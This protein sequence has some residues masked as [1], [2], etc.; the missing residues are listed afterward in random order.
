MKKERLKYLPIVLSAT[1]IF[2]VSFYAF[3]RWQRHHLFCEMLTVGMPES[4]VVRIMEKVGNF[5]IGRYESFI[6][7]EDVTLQVQSSSNLRTALIY[8]TRGLELHFKAGLLVNAIER[9]KLED[10]IYKLCTD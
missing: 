1:I 8:G 3:Q 10:G 9:Y 7:S 2:S 6:D 4:E 5:E